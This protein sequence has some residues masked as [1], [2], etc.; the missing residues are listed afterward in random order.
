MKAVFRVVKMKG[1]KLQ[2]AALRKNGA[3]VV[4]Y[5]VRDPERYG[6]VFF[7]DNDRPVQ[8]QEKPKNPKSN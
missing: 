7:D 6:I 3:T 5:R 4:A 8:I 1:R 2:K